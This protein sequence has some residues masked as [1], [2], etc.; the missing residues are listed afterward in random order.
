MGGIKSS[1]TMVRAIILVLLFLC[2]VVNPSVAQ[3]RKS[4]EI[5][6]Q[7]ETNDDIG[8]KEGAWNE[9]TVDLQAN[10][11]SLESTN[12][13]LESKERN[14]W[15]D[16]I[17]SRFLTFSRKKNTRES[18]GGV[19]GNKK[20]KKAF[21][22]AK[23]KRGGG[24]KKNRIKIA[25][26]R[27]KGGRKRGGRNKGG[28]KAFRKKIAKHFKKGKKGKRGKRTKISTSP[29][30]VAGYKPP[31]SFT[32]P[33]LESERQEPQNPL[34]LPGA[35]D[36]DR[37]EPQNPLK[38][39]VPQLSPGGSVP[40]L[41][42][43]GGLSTQVANPPA[44]QPTPVPVALPPPPRHHQSQRELHPLIHQPIRHRHRLSRRLLCQRRNQRQRLCQHQCR[45]RL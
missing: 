22:A 29:N 7:D 38:G 10:D 28:K 35:Q 37:V 39:S 19:K 11:A 25:G 3:L 36:A 44:P 32:A 24:R 5:R 18:V 4:Q 6:H 8:R 20:L 21:G 17:V 2:F 1:A 40:Q 30:K 45:R 16:A 42:S 31:K 41:L 43:P 9:Y 23:R 13:D 34:K 27:K 26:V 33:D 15:T 12:E 14:G